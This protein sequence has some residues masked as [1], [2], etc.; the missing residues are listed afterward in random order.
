MSFL[1]NPC[2]KN[3]TDTVLEAD[4]HL[5]EILYLKNEILIALSKV[6]CLCT[7]TQ[8]HP[9]CNQEARSHTG[10]SGSIYFDQAFVG[11]ED[12]NR[13]IISVRQ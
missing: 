2:Q 13:I 11:Q 7:K 5:A 12:Y 1:L 4:G 8:I 10:Y 6:P 3:M 9:M